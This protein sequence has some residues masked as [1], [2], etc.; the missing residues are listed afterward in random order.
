MQFFFR[1]LAA[2]DA[3]KRLSELGYLCEVAA[4]LRIS[5][6]Q[7]AFSARLWQLTGREDLQAIRPIQS[8]SAF[9]LFVPAS[10][11]LYGLLSK[12]THFEYD[13]HTHFFAKGSNRVFT[14]QRGAVL[15]AYAT[16]LVF[17]TM[18]CISK[19]VLQVSSKQ[20][21]TVPTSVQELSDFVQQVNQ[22]S[23]D[24]CL[25]LKGDSVLAQLD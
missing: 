24:V 15:R 2:F 22:Y 23:D 4:I 5:L 7:F 25:I 6:E 21:A 3:S 13:H 10:G 1:N 17:L 19:Y 16:H 12:Y 9:K 11:R 20:F 14:M 18:A 8:L